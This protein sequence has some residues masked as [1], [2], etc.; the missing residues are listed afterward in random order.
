MNQNIFHTF[1]YIFSIHVEAPAKRIKRKVTEI[2]L[3]FFRFECF[4]A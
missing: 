4:L 1:T 2:A 3:I